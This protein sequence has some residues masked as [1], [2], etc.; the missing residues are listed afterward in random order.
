VI[1]APIFNRLFPWCTSPGVNLV[2]KSHQIVLRSAWAPCG[3]VRRWAVGRKAV[4]RQPPNRPTAQ[5]PNRPT[6]QPPNRSSQRID[7]LKSWESSKIGVCARQHQPTL[8]RQRRQMSIGGEITCRARLLEERFP[9][10]KMSIR[11]QGYENVER[12]AEGEAHACHD[13][14]EAY[15]EHRRIWL[16]SPSA[17]GCGWFLLTT[18]S[19]SLLDWT[20]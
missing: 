9:Q 1:G 3:A 18:V 6:A 4:S 12:A 20:C 17:P 8:D 2:T 13:R 14:A 19:P 15:W 5:P 7:P 10:R 16:P 11:R